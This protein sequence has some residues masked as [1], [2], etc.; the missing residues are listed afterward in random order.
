MSTMTTSK[1]TTGFEIAIVGMSC[2]FPGIAN[3]REFWDNLVNGVE[4]LSTYTDEELQETGVLR[5]DIVNPLYVKS[6]FVLENKDHFDSNFFGY[7]PVD[8]SFLNPQNRIFYE[9]VWEALE[10]A[11]YNTDIEKKSIGL[12]A[13]GG[14]DLNWRVFTQL[15]NI[16][17]T[18]DNLTLSNLNSREYMLS[19]LAYRLNFMGPVYITNTA[20]STSMVA[21]NLACKSLLLGE[22]SVA[23]AGGVSVNTRTQKGYMYEEGMIESKDGHCRA[24]DKDST[25]TVWSEGS[26]VVILKR[27]DDAVKQGDHIY[28]VIKGGAI[29]NDGNRKVGFTAPSVEG[30]VECIKR[31]QKMAG[32]DP[33][34][35]TYVETHGTGTKIGDPIEVE[36][37]NIAFNK[38]TSHHCAIGSVKTNIGHTDAAAGVAGLIKASLC[39]KYKKIPPSINFNEENPGIRFKEGPFFVNTK[40]TDWMPVGDM[41]LRAGVSS[42]GVGGTN[43][44]VILEQAPEVETGLPGNPYKI[45]AVSAKTESALTRYI[46]K[47]KDFL[48]NETNI[49]SDDLS[50]S[51]LKGRKSFGY[52]KSIAYTDNDDLIQQ[53]NEL[54]KEQAIKSMDDPKSIVFMFPGQGSQYNNMCKDLYEHIPAF[55]KQI[56]EGLTL[57]Q[58]LTGEDFSAVLFPQSGESKTINNTRYTQPL[59]FVVEYALA[60]YLISLGVSPDYMIGH[61]IG[62]YV[63]AC[64]SQVFSFED[65]VKLVLTRGTL[66]NRVLPGAMLSVP[67]QEDKALKYIDTGISLAAVNGPESIVLS[68]SIEAMEELKTRL[69]KDGVSYIVL[70]TSHAFHSAMQDGIMDEFRAELEKVNFRKPV[71]EFVSNLTGRLITPEDAMSPGYW[72]RHMRNTVR[73]SE[74]IKTIVSNSN[75]LIFIEV[76]AGR[77]LCTLLKQHKFEK[78]IILTGV[79]MVRA[80]K[81]SV[82]DFRYITNQIGQLW[83]NGAQANWDE[84]FGNQLRRKIS[85]PTYAFDPVKYLAEVNISEST[86]LQGNGMVKET[87]TDLANWFHVPYWKRQNLPAATFKQIDIHEE[88]VILIFMDE[89]G[90]GEHLIQKMRSTGNTIIPIRLGKEFSK[91]SDGYIINPAIETDF[92]KLFS[93]L[94][95]S[96]NKLN[97]LITYLWGINVR[98]DQPLTV[99][100][101][102]KKQDTLYNSLLS[103]A[104]AISAWNSNISTFLKIVSNNLFD[105]SGGERLTAENAMILG[106]IYT[107]PLEYIN[108]R[109]CGIDIDFDG[110]KTQSETIAGDLHR[111]IYFDVADNLVAYRNS[112]RWTRAFE[113]VKLDGTA[114]VSPFTDGSVYL[115]TGGTGGIGLVSAE[116]I[117]QTA[118]TTILLTGRSYFPPREAWEKEMAE[119][120]DYD[121]FKKTL[122]RLK[123]IED[124]GSTVIYHQVDVT[125]EQSMKQFAEVIRSKY[126][127]VNG[128]IH[129]AGVTDGQM[130]E[131]SYRGSS[132]GI[133]KPK[134]NGTILLKQYF[135]DA[136]FMFLSST[137]GSVVPFPGQTAYS[138]VN[139]FLD[140]FAHYNT[141][142][143]MLTTSINWDGWRDSGLALATNVNQADFKNYN[144]QDTRIFGHHLFKRKV[145]VSDSEMVYISYLSTARYWYLDEHRISKETTFMPGTG[146]LELMR[147]AFEFQEHHSIIEMTDV[148]FLVPMPFYNDDERE[149]HTNITYQDGV[150]NISVRSR[151]RTT[152][153]MGEWVTHSMSVVRK[154]DNST[155]LE[156]RNIVQLNELCTGEYLTKADN[157][158]E[159]KYKN[160]FGSRWNNRNWVRRGKDHQLVL[161]DMPENFLTD[162]NEYSL[163]PAILDVATTFD[164]ELWD[165]DIFLPFK[166]EKLTIL[167]PLPAR[168]FSFISRYKE[169]S[170]AGDELKYDIVVTDED[171]RVLV[172][173]TGFTRMRLASTDEHKTGIVTELKKNSHRLPIWLVDGLTDAEGLEAF[174]RL[175]RLKLPQIFVVGRTK[176]FNRFVKEQVS[177]KKQEVLDMK[178]SSILAPGEYFER[179]QLS[180]IYEAPAT[181]MEEL[182]SHTWQTFFGY[183]KVGVNDDFFEL[184]GDSLKVMAVVS[185]TQKMLNASIPLKEFFKKATV[186]GLAAYLDAN[187]VMIP[188]NILADHSGEIEEHK[189]IELDVAQKMEVISEEF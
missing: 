146:Y 18:I 132:N 8:A 53:L 67:M 59:I 175:S 143:G 81:E 186:S 98:V 189:I 147:T 65:A 187:G 185:I 77:S 167:A 133:I 134:I 42:F 66:M 79:N 141:R 19:Q 142:E 58:V 188:E 106:P 26:G 78:S 37:L 159:I 92:E 32:V 127:K 34:S 87:G 61:S 22:C 80:P 93:S 10:D 33:E 11:G 101:F 163:H 86:F 36:A 123:A 24:F 125:D 3:W 176:D 23:V 164:L 39:L 131:T 50:Y 4:S 84:W 41:P 95:S 38:N 46:D 47:F 107:I 148:V 161:L 82:N 28:A 64:I 179:P 110:S 138:S 63:A 57:L 85:L 112:Q 178:S 119:L 14:E 168:C 16:D 151:I 68:G 128:I 109:V 69:D 174:K 45:F 44:H 139:N 115:I 1:K 118:K 6:G 154:L 135:S 166:Y 31:A 12:F 51:L 156:M 91:T 150:Y 180:T 102:E 29:N 20:C 103:I 121:G 15:K 40:T 162:F 153:A 43:A 169:N 157:P 21:I 111:E 172:D 27:L 182:L 9:C 94:N 30:Q 136:G 25:G 126:G 108:T 13:G 96:G 83:C 181:K 60:N 75:K 129:S 105:V 7:K 99:D 76:G 70:H 155:S 184:G 48:V 183:D 145:K 114:G 54:A 120:P 71:Y 149:V 171:G 152:D 74:G 140:A 2:R 52:R 117:A 72:V 35:I 170:I 5:S 158:D 97:L 49:N 144:I 130:I 173:I 160:L 177:T 113:S 137:V 90:I 17:A 100:A 62:E 104:R 165:S 122:Y 56:D 116:H 73:F 89:Y 55:R 124:A 88:S